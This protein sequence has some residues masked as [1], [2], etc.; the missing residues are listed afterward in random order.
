MKALI[1]PSDN[2]TDMQRLS[3]EYGEQSLVFNYGTCRLTD[4]Q[5]VLWGKTT[6]CS[7]SICCTMGLSLTSMLQ[8][9]LS[10]QLYSRATVTV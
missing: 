4:D 9:M 10:E 2:V 6:D 8:P 1:S 5:Q 3:T 7:K